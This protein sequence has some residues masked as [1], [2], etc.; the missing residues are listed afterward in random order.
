MLGVGGV[1]DTWL[2]LHWEAV[3]GAPSYRVGYRTD[4]GPLTWITVGNVLTYVLT[5]LDNDVIVEWTV[6]AESPAGR[7]II[8]ASAFS[9]PLAASTPQPLALWDFTGDSSFEPTRNPTA[10]SAAVA[11][12]PLVRGAGF[13][14][15]ARDETGALDVDYH[16]LPDTFGFIPVEDSGNFGRQPGGGDL[17]MAIGRNLHLEFTLVPEENRTLSVIAIETGFA[18]PHFAA[19]LLAELQYRLGDGP[20]QSGPGAPIAIPGGDGTIGNIAQMVPA[21]FDLSG[22]SAL[23]DTAE[24]I[25]FRF[26]L[27]STEESVRYCRAGLGRNEGPDLVVH[28]TYTESTPTLLARYHAWRD[29]H[30]TP[31]EIAAGD[32][33]LTADP[34]DTGEPNWVAFLFGGIPGET[35]APGPVPTM[36]AT[37]NGQRLALTFQLPHGLADGICWIETSEDLDTWTNTPVRF[38]RRV[39]STIAEYDLLEFTDQEPVGD[40]LFYRLATDLTTWE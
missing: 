40:Y 18:Y 34:H 11:V 25:T 19:T 13:D 30:Y 37:P 7:G 16:P 26:Y 23:Q 15:G 3:P 4:S 8:A 33:D 35:L 22:V 32:A 27:Y 10:R 17:A 12:S 28:G 14:L 36:I 38:T 24:P 2:S 9:T 1:G 20:W 31:E 39:V 29:L 21:S 5:G 6:Q